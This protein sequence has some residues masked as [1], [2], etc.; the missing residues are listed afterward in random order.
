MRHTQCAACPFILYTTVLVPDV[1]EFAKGATAARKFLN[2]GNAHP[3][4]SQFQF[5]DMVS[6]TTEKEINELFTKLDLLY[7]DLGNKRGLSER[8]KQ[9]RDVMK[10]Q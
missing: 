10:V 8:K 2:S 5:K 6:S 3:S 9:V 1:D 4:N 7:S